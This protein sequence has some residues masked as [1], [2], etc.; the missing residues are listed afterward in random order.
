MIFNWF[1][2][3]IEKYNQISISM[4]VKYQVRCK[5]NTKFEV[6]KMQLWAMSRM[7]I[8][9]LQI[10]IRRDRNKLCLR[11]REV[12]CMI[13]QF[14]DD[15]FQRLNKNYLKGNKK[16]TWMISSFDDRSLS[17][18]EHYPFSSKVISFR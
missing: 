7:S 13:E 8:K 4:Q 2:W 5:L 12:V 18:I 16:N 11:L 17:V 14:N 6:E 15:N 9:D 10:D 1:E 3:L